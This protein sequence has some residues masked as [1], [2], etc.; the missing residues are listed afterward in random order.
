MFFIPG[1]N[2][3]QPATVR[4]FG[5]IFTDVDLSDSTWIEFFGATITLIFNQT[6]S[7]GIVDD[8]SLSFL[9]AVGSEEIFRVR[10]ISGNTPIGSSAEDPAKGVDLVAMDDFIYAEPRSVPESGVGIGLMGLGALLCP[11]LPPPLSGSMLKRGR[12]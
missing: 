12:Q 4:G 6:V 8:K 3:V 5:A 2:G 1:T 10:I 7:P 11:L 9:G